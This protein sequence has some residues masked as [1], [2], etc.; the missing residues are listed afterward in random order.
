MTEESVPEILCACAAVRRAARVLTQLYADEFDGVIEVTQYSILA[1]VNRMPGISQAQLAN[2]L[3]LDET[4][5]SRNLGLIK[6]QGWISALAGRD[7]RKRGLTI[8]PEGL[9]LLNAAR[10]AWK[11]SQARLKKALGRDDWNHLLTAVDNVTRVAKSMKEN[12]PM[13]TGARK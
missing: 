6:R 4:T 2:H 5:L 8:T 12:K 7:R 1:I 10:P 3:A 13:A 11:R 9:L